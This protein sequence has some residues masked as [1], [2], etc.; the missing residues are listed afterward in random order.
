M[1]F[2]TTRTSRRCVFFTEEW[3]FTCSHNASSSIVKSVRWTKSGSEAAWNARKWDCHWLMK[4]LYLASDLPFSRCPG[5]LMEFNRQVDSAAETNGDLQ[6]G[7]HCKRGKCEELTCSYC[8]IPIPVQ[9]LYIKCGLLK[10]CPFCGSRA[11]GSSSSLLLL[12]FLISPGAALLPSCQSSLQPF[13]G[14][15]TA[16]AVEWAVEARVSTTGCFSS[17]TSYPRIRW[18]LSPGG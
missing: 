15:T 9:G 17:L 14:N 11:T 3:P 1:V 5:I 10:T 6:W 2:L 8:L 13:S 7:W 16:V 12:E 18:L 4:D